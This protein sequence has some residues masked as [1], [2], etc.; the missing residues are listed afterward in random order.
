MAIRTIENIDISGKKVLIRV[1]FNVPLANGLIADDTRMRSALP[2]LRYLLDRGAALV[3][4]S[5]M[6]RPKGQKNMQYSMKQLQGHLAALTRAEVIMAPDVIG[7]EV[8]ELALMLRSGQILLLENTRFYSQETD[9]EPNF[10]R[11]LARL[12]DVYVND[13][14]GAAHR[15]HAST[16][17]V[18]KFLPS[19][20]G[21]LMKK[22]CSFFDKVLKNPVKPF[23]AVIGGAKVSSKIAVLESLLDKAD[24]FIIGGGM[25]YT[26][27]KEQGKTVGKSLVEN[28]YAD[29]AHSF[30]DNAA[31]RGVSILLPRDHIVADEFIESAKP[32][33]IDDENIPDGK[34]AMDIG[35]KT[36]SEMKKLIANAGTVVW[37]GPMGVF[38]FDAFSQGTLELAKTVADCHGMT[39]LGGGDSV[40]AVNKFNLSERIDHV[41]TGGG[42][43]LEYLEGRVLPGIAALN[44]E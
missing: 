4:M 6:G 26:F 35:P 1:D 44:E 43:S 10:C 41:S 29:T 32:E 15:A 9:N 24:A 8:E 27:L 40:A 42:A 13:A 36:I 31:R 21:L 34:I 25:A 3:I 22:E 30:L 18:T 2:T 38:E 11:S 17:G 19:Y 20:A 28:E 37:N 5:H 33:L 12:G 7:P 39:V 14:F 16:E 23:V